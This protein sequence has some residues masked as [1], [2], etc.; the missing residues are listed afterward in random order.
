L[1]RDEFLFNPHPVNCTGPNPTVSNVDSIIVRGSGP[2]TF[3][4]DLR[5]G[6][7]EP[8]RTD[9]SDGSSEI[10][11][12]VGAEVDFE[13]ID[14]SSADDHVTLGSVADRTGANLNA[15]ESSADVD[16]L[17]PKR[18]APAIE[19]G[20]GADVLSSVGERGFNEP[21][22]FAAFAGGA[23]NDKLLGGAGRDSL[24]GGPGDDLISGGPGN[25]YVFFPEGRDEVDCG[26]GRDT[27]V[28]EAGQYSGCEERIDPDDFFPPPID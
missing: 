4:L 20:G 28:T 22:G 18:R 1:V 12:R 27:I 11:L 9:E 21:P 19:A 10:E 6:P 3:S 7:L 5:R 8:G 16:V 24:W 15:G 26:T 13:G 14:L 17:V 2:S 23:G 25:D